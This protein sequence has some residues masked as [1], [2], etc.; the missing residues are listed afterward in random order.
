MSD[1]LDDAWGAWV[2]RQTEQTVIDPKLA[3]AAGWR[4]SA[5]MTVR[6]M[7]TVS[8]LVPALRELADVLGDD[9]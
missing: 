7:T 1:V 4:D 8:T 3:Y 2:G 5:K 9:D 6:A